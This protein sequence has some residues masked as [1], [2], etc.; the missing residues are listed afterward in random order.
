MT[1]RAIID[2]HLFLITIRG[3]LARDE[4]GTNVPI[5]LE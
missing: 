5:P 3:R 2:A 1:Y 4:G